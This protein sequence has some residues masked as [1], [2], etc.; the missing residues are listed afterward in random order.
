MFYSEE[1]L[2]HVC[3]E[4]VHGVLCFFEP[5]NCWFAANADTALQISSKGLK[6]H[7]IPKNVFENAGLQLNFECDY[8]KNE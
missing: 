2:V 5:D 8:S 3:L 4:N 1:N 7:I 6:F